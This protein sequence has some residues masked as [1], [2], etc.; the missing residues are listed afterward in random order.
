MDYQL[1]TSNNMIDPTKYGVPIQQGGTKIDISKYGS[2]VT[3]TKTPINQGEN[4]KLQKDAKY[5][6][7]PIGLTIETTKG[8]IGSLLSTAAKFI[9]SAAV[10]PIDLGRGVM[11]KQ[12]LQVGSIQSDFSNKL[13]QPQYQSGLG[14]A[15]AGAEAVTDTALG[16]L[17]V[18]S[19]GKGLTK[20]KNTQTTKWLQNT[21][22]TLSS[23]EEKAASLE[24]RVK[25]TLGGSKKILPSETEK[26]AT[27]LLKGKVTSSVTKNPQIIQKEIA[28]RGAGVESYLAKNA[29]VVTAKEQAD[30][31]SAARTTM[32]KYATKTEL[33][34]YDEQ[35]KTFTKQLVGRGGYTTDNFYKA[36]KEFEQNVT[37]NLPKGKVA[38]IGDNLGQGSARI[39]AAQDIRTVVRDMIGQKHPEFKG[40]MFDLAS[41]YDVLD[42]ALTKSRQ[43]SGNAFSRFAD[44]NPLTTGAIK[45]GATIGTGALITKSLLNKNS[46]SFSSLNSIGNE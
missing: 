45:Y 23:M 12:P 19:I 39:R 34:A 3:S 21:P 6:N 2:P 15:Q 16:A 35:M 18:L 26:R 46:Q 27:K 36:L 20:L 9:K 10:S 5:L 41:L 44:N 30:M 32:E 37:R 22:D 33:K 43:L 4:A 17:D 13:S 14:M 31:F 8:T 1:N 25:T 28:K 38:L 40:K 7:S 11:G 42:T 29:K 24:G